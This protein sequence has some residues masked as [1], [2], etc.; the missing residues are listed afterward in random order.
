MLFTRLTEDQLMAHCG[1]CALSYCLWMSGDD[2]DQRQIARL[3]GAP[4]ATFINGMGLE[5]LV[6]A[7]EAVGYRAI[8]VE[9]NAPKTTKALKEHIRRGGTAVVYVDD[10]DHWVAALDTDSAGRFIIDDPYD[11]DEVFF[12]MSGKDLIEHA[13]DD[14]G[15]LSALFIY[16][17]RQWKLTEDFI[18]LCEE[19]ARMSAVQLANLLIGVVSSSPGGRGGPNIYTLM[20]KHK[21]AILAR[22]GSLTED[23]DV[24]ANY[25]EL[26]VVAGAVG[27]DSGPGVDAK[28]ATEK[29]AKAIV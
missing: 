10:E 7:T 1:P 2:Y 5:G 27:L 23:E 17:K 11:K 20:Q 8:M 16:N 21:R 3:G 19:G 15:T 9:L 13:A 4:Y 22:A 24:E 6:K 18:D 26:F 12:R 14:D 25:H 29:L 28:E